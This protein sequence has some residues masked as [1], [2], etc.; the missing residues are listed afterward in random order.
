MSTHFAD[1]LV[2]APW[3]LRQLGFEDFNRLSEM[4]RAPEFEGWSEDGRQVGF[5]HV[6]GE[7]T[8][9]KDQSAFTVRCLGLVPIDDAQGQRLDLPGGDRWRQAPDGQIDKR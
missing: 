8:V 9:A 3:A 6:V 1:K 5:R 2:L 4:L 7:G